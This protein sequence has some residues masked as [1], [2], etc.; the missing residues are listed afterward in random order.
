MGTRSLNRWYAS[1]RD[2]QVALCCNRHWK[3]HI[4]AAQLARH[5]AMPNALTRISWLIQVMRQGPVSGHH[6]RGQ[7]ERRESAVSGRRYEEPPAT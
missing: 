5:S 2:F 3:L 1:R 7:L 4:Y 6:T